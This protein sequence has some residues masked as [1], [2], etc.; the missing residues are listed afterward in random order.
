MKRC[1]PF[2]GAALRQQTAFGASPIVR[3]RGP[4]GI[5]AFTASLAGSAADNNQCAS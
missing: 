4:D 5:I 2:K 3:A 1:L